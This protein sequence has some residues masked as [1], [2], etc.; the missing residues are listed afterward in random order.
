MDYLK[1]FESAQPELEQWRQR[2]VR[3]PP[4]EPQRGSDLAEDDKVFPYQRISEMTRISLI[5]AGEHLR[6]VWDALDRKNLYTTAQHTAVRGALV[7]AAQ[8]VWITAPD[9]AATRQRRGHSVIAESYDQLRKYQRRTL[10]LADD[11]G[12]T[13]AQQQL[14]RDQIDWITGRLDAL[15]AV[16]PALMKVN[17]ADI[18]RDIGP[19]VFPGDTVRQGGLRLAWNTL[20]SDAHVLMWSIATR[21]DFQAAGPADRATGLS[22]GIAGGQLGDLA[23]WYDLTMNTLRRGW[24]LFDRRCEA[25]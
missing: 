11:L 14:V 3:N 8:A 22:V 24:R 9:D 4:E 10:D 5:S 25:P 15:T 13:A 6:L 16:Q 18:L 20:S 12:N 21:A 2:Q 19:I 7:G 1:V 17:V 23:G